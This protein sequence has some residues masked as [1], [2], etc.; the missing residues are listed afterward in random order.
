MIRLTVQFFSECFFISWCDKNI[1]KTTFPKFGRINNLLLSSSTV[2]MLPEIKRNTRK[3]FTLESSLFSY[4]KS[5][6]K[7]RSKTLKND[8]NLDNLKLIV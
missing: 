6:V 2:H 5:T 1:V 4:I 7:K 3:N 8:L